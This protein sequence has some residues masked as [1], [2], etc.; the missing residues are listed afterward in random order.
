MLLINKKIVMSRDIGIHGNLFG[1]TLMAW[2]D[3]SA[4]AFAT[5]YCF[6]PNMVTVR[7]GELIFK[8]PLKSGQHV[9]IYGEVERLGDTSISLNLEARKYSLYSAEETVVCTTSF[10]FVRIDDDGTPTSIGETVKKRYEV[11]QLNRALATSN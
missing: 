4:A 2:L 8:K 11:Q 3:E 1:G 9:R 10:T 5:E 7:V 6:T